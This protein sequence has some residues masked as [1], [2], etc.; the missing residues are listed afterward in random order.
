MCDLYDV[1]TSGYYAWRNRPLSKR[2]EEDKTLLSKI[3]AVFNASDQSYGSP[4][5]HRALL[6]QKQDVGRR[7]V[8]RIMREHGIRACSATRTRRSST[9]RLHYGSVDN[10]VYKKEVTSTDQVWVGDVTYLSVNGQRRYLATVMDRYS[11]RILGWAYGRDRTVNLTRRA[12]YNA[13]KVRR[14]KAEPYFHTDRGTEYMADSYRKTL[15][16]A[17]FIQSA[18][19]PRRMNDNAHMESW[20]KSMKSDM[21]HRRIFTS[22]GQL[23]NAMRSYIHYYN[24]ERLHSS[25]GYRTPMEIDSK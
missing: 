18:N 3:N 22:D 4:R 17:G 5:V 16:N 21:Y 2:A 19:R 10:R 11:R 7:R 25:L 9:M 20:Y 23:V 1:T 14:P 8:E 13:L 24:Y 6:F 12:F 15:S